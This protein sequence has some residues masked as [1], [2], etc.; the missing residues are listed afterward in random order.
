LHKGDV[1]TI[2]EGLP[3]GVT[4]Y[5]AGTAL[6]DGA[7][8]TAGGRVLAVTAVADTIGE[9]HRL[10]CEAAERIEF[11]GKQFRRDIGWREARRD[12]SRG[13]SGRG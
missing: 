11:E 8:V 9:A 1:I 5:H 4:V 10:S 2:P 6:Q 12:S 7:L 13:P 3:A